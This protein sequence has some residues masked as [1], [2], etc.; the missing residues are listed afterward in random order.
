LTFAR[1]SDDPVLS[2]DG[3]RIVFQS[4][5]NG[6]FDLYRKASNGA[7]DDE[8]LLQSDQNK[9]PTSW[10]RDGRFLLYNS[11]DPKTEDDIWVLPLDGSQGAPGKP[12]PFLRT[13]FNEADGAF[14]PDGRWIAYA[15]TE[16][17]T[18]EV[19]VRPFTPPEPGVSASAG[20]AGKWQ[21][22]KNGVF[23][24]VPLWRADGKELYY[25]TVSGTLMAVEVSTNPTFQ[26]GSPRRLFDA[27][28]GALI[29]ATADGKK[30]LVGMPQQDTGPSAITVVL[31]WQS[32]L[33]K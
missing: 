7:G 24:C 33:K 16:S 20:A 5:R 9:Y 30:F 26:A 1:L 28:A 21:V 14:S 2:P 6:K 23:A 19:Y 25:R 18:I 11:T 10:S 31:N 3:S 12:F 27:P 17:G 29:D 32:E 22:S 8:I 13:E 4:N 15:S